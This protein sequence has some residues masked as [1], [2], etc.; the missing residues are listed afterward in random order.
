MKRLL[1]CLFVVFLSNFAVAS[2]TTDTDRWETLRA[3]NLVENPTNQTGYG[4]KGEL[5]PYQFRS[6]TWRMHT[7]K[8]FRMAND[9]A[10]A[11]QVAVQHYEWIAAR[12]KAAGIDANSYNIA[13]AWNCGLSAVV[14]GRIPMQSYHYAERVNNLASDFR[15]QVDETSEM[16]VVSTKNLSPVAA[17]EFKLATGN[18][19]TQI[20]FVAGPSE[21]R[22]VNEVPRLV[23][24]AATPRFVLAAN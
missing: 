14:S 15:R 2:T 24:A 13:L 7:S 21:F 4:S 8:S 6:S 12:L 18:A 11:D 22:V 17:V 20:R 3:I 10:T 5:G 9:R 1:T 23:F 16:V 19:A